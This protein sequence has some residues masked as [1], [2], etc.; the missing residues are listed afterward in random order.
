MWVTK[1]RFH[2][3]TSEG[4]FKHERNDA[5]TSLRLFSLFEYCAHLFPIKRLPKVTP[6][7]RKEEIIDPNSDP[8]SDRSD[9]GD[10]YTGI[11]RKA[12]TTVT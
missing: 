9:S 6:T 5:I 7:V 11:Y 8:Q 3:K 4:L 1:S 10:G 12:V 2:W